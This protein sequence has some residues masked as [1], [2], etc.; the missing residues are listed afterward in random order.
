MTRTW[1]HDPLPSAIDGSVTIHGSILGP[2][3]DAE[4]LP[5]DTSIVDDGGGSKRLTVTEPIVA[6]GLRWCVILITQRGKL[7]G[8]YMTEKVSNDGGWATW[9]EAAE[10]AR[11][12]RYEEWLQRAYGSASP[13]FPWGCCGA[14][15][16][17][18]SGF[19]AVNVTFDC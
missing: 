6:D 1:Q 9:S 4:K 11:G 14:G 2:C 7:R 10:V 12:R 16:D 18:R 15:Y 13:T 3:V 19:A 5:F 17:G 8:L